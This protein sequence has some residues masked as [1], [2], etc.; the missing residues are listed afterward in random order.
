MNKS[1]IVIVRVTGDNLHGV[2]LLLLLLFSSVASRSIGGIYK[3]TKRYH[4]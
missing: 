3:I 4:S 1:M 2:W